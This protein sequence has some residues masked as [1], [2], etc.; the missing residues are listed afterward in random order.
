MYR[1]RLRQL[2]VGFMGLCAGAASLRNK[3]L[4]GGQNLGGRKRGRRP[5]RTA[6]ENAIGCRRY[7]M[8][9]TRYDRAGRTEFCS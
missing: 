4:G 5:L 6:H 7:E 9:K 1:K 2:C 3:E 8:L